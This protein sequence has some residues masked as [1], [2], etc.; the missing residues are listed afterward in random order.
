LQGSEEIL[1]GRWDALEEHQL[2]MIGKLP[3][4]LL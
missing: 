2:Y 4:E 3:E 1:A